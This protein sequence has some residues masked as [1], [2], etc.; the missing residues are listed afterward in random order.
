[1]ATSCVP[2]WEYGMEPRANYCASGTGLGLCT[3]PWPWRS[4][5]WPWAR[6]LH[7]PQTKG[8]TTTDRSS[9]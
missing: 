5:P 2:L 3:W 9:A 1:M 6:E 8:S 4:R 7:L